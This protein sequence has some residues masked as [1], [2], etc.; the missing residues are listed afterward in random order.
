MRWVSEQKIRDYK[1]QK[2]WK[3]GIILAP[4]LA[5]PLRMQKELLVL[6][7]SRLPYCVVRSQNCY[8]TKAETCFTRKKRFCVLVQAHDSV[9]AKKSRRLL[10]L[11]KRSK[12][13]QYIYRTRIRQSIDLNLYTKTSCINITIKLWVKKGK[14]GR[15]K[16]EILHLIE[17]PKD[18]ILSLSLLHTHI[19]TLRIPYYLNILYLSLSLFLK[20]QEPV[21]ITKTADN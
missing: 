5:L 17:P 18:T 16:K 9:Q 8:T 15:H 12:R 19:H 13:H 1:I 2:P 4:R 20:F 10:L 21:W 7:S 6:C 3:V 11:R 14:K